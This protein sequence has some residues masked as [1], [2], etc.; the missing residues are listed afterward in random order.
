MPFR[1]PGIRA[2]ERL[3]G[4]TSRHF[5]DLPFGRASVLQVILVILVCASVLLDL[6]ATAAYHRALTR[7]GGLV[8]H[9]DA[10]YH[11][12]YDLRYGGMGAPVVLDWGMEA[13]VRFLSEGSVRPIEVFGYSSLSEPDDAFVQRIELFLGNVDNVYLLRAPGNELFQG[14][15][16]VFERLVNERD[17]QLERAQ[18]YTQQDGTPLYELWRVRY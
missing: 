6:W 17:G 16:E 1:E 2:W 18:V 15:R 12:A 9:S 14:R 3:Q 11:L 7:S 13:P 5:L 10:S 8:D 4:L